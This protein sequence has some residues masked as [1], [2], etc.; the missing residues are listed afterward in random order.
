MSACAECDLPQ[1]WGGMDWHPHS[2]E[3]HDRMRRRLAR[4]MLRLLAERVAAQ[5]GHQV[6]IRFTVLLA[7]AE[8]SCGW[9]GLNWPDSSY[10]R[11]DGHDHL[12]DLGWVLAAHALLTATL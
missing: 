1:I 7:W 2:A 9:R 11:G 6:T 5:A 12:A 4:H 10:A 3:Q 8:C